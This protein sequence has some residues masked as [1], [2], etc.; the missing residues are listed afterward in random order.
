M[1]SFTLALAAFIL[2]TS[3]SAAT[4]ERDAAFRADFNLFLDDAMK[5][6]DTVPGL[7]VA[8]VHANGPVQT[9]GLGYAD[10]T[11]RIP[12]TPKTPFYIASSTKAV[13]GATFAALAQCGAI[14]L[15]WTLAELAPDIRFDPSVTASRVTLRHLLTHTH[16]LKN[17]ALAWRL[18]YTGDPGR[19][20]SWGILAHTVA[21]P[22][23]PPGTYRYSNV[24]YN[25]AAMLI[26]RKLGK[27]WQDLVEAE[28]LLPLGMIH[29]FA[30]G[31]DRHAVA[32]PYFGAGPKGWEAG[33]PK[34]DATLHSAG[35][36]YSDANDMALWLSAQLRAEAGEQTALSAALRDGHKP[37]AT[38]SDEFA[39]F[40]RTAY[41]L[42]WYSGA[43]D[44]ADLYHAFGN[45]SGFRAHTSFSP[46]LDL[47]VAVMSNDE[48]IGFRLT[49]IVAAF[50]YNWYGR[51]PEYAKA[52]GEVAIAAF[53][54]QEVAFPARVA[55]QRAKLAGRPWLLSQPKAAYAGRWCHGEYDDLTI[56]IAGDVM[57]VR[58]ARLSSIA[59]AY[60]APES[61]RIEFVPNSGEVMA[62]T[63][64]Q[65]KVTGLRFNEANF[66]RDCH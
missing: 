56:E 22:K 36:L 7:S 55:D 20:A 26:E 34:T 62:F 41:G 15:D 6:L 42:G 66:S 3:A 4:P 37:S 29:T 48:A 39:G 2:A 60:T 11:R 27:R 57:I 65:G 52:Q 64:N 38:L 28:V 58:M 50:A 1:K 24:G 5:R 33:L 25:I 61:I 31:L 9:R 49:D 23:T 53:D 18:A 40:T 59:S 17:D 54:A 8:V 16:G 12:T 21:D 30:D 47:G 13:V 19:A 32:L 63:V 44:G 10:L 14:N 51:G 46:S 43:Y 35:G 45:F